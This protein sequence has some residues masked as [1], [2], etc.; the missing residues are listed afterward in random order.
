VGSS[1]DERA[2]D[3]YI[4]HLEGLEEGAE[5]CLLIDMLYASFL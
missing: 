4:G 3:V 2:P 1:S 5:G